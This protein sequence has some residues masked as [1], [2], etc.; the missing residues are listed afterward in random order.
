MVKLFILLKLDT[1]FSD[2]ER[3]EFSY[4]PPDMTVYVGRDGKTAVATW[5]TPTVRDNINISIVPRLTKGLAPGS[6]FWL[7]VHAIK[8][9][10]EDAAHNKADPCI[11]IITVQGR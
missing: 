11:F 6:R 2:I 8:Y 4:C 1:M 7:G 5:L 10:A 9:R 3:P